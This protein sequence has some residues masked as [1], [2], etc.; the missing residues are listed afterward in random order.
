MR[1][2]R[3][4]TRRHLAI[5]SDLRARS[6]ACSSHAPVSLSAPRSARR[7]WHDSRMIEM[8]VSPR[9]LAS[10]DA[11]APRHASAAVTHSDSSCRILRVGFGSSSP[12][13]VAATGGA[14]PSHA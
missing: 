3:G 11:P 2:T 7:R 14:T 4:A 1:P 10:I 8:G 12:S 5:R 9:W 6:S 13:P